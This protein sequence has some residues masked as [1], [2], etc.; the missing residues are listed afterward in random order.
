MGSTSSYDYTA[1]SDADINVTIEIENYPATIEN[2]TEEEI[3]S[4]C[5]SNWICTDWSECS[6]EIQYRNCSKEIYGCYADIRKKPIESQSCIEDTSAYGV[7]N[8][9]ISN[10]K[11]NYRLYLIVGSSLVV[12]ILIIFLVLSFFFRKTKNSFKGKKNL[13][14]KKYS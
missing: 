13:R 3:S 8:E 6:N 7:L 4:G 14:E 9:T 2:L 10:L 5:I 11:L 1:S 12:I